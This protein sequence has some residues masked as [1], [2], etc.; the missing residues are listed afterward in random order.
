MATSEVF[1]MQIDKPGGHKDQF[2]RQTRAHHVAL[3]QMADM[4]ANLL[5]TVSSLVITLSLKFVTD[6]QTFWPMIILMTGCAV[7]A[8]LAAHA[9]MPK[10]RL[11]KR[12]QQPPGSEAFDE[13]LLF[14]A[15][16]IHLSYPDYAARMERVLNDDNL[17]YEAQVREVYT[18]GCYLAREKYRWVRY[19]YL[20]FIVSIVASALSYA[21]VATIYHA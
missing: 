16:F 15:D 21:L 6:A 19:A 14:F 12:R 13:N 2:I 18:M 5:I 17:I 8:V 11:G 3:S 4:K 9:T 1:N 20:S 7:T 10:L